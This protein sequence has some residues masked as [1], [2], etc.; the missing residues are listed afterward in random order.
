MPQQ[1]F[2]SE[3]YKIVP[4]EKKNEKKKIFNFKKCFM[5]FLFGI[6]VS[7]TLKFKI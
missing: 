2:I 4:Y 3:K 7:A 6:Y 5:I 1:T